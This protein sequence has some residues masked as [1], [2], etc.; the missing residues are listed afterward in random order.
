[1]LLGQALR[2]PGRP[3][4]SGNFGGVRV[5]HTGHHR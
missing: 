2:V 3:D 5:C 4:A 1:L